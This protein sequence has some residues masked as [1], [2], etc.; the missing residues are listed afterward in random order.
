MS[1]YYR[2]NHNIEPIKDNEDLA[3]SYPK[4]HTQPIVELHRSFA[5]RI[6]KSLSKS[7]LEYLSK[8]LP[9]YIIEP[10]KP[11]NKVKNCRKIFLEIGFGM[12]E[13]LA[14]QATKNTEYYY[15]GCEPYMNGVAN[16]LKLATNNN[17]SNI[18]IWPDTVDDILGSLPEESIDGVYILF[19]DP[20]PKN[21]QQKRRLVNLVR[22]SIIYKAL[23][24]N[25]IV[26]FASDIYHYVDR[27]KEFM[28][29][30]GFMVN[31]LR[32]DEPYAGYVQTKYHLKAEKKATPPKF[33]QFIKI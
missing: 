12:G 20:W 14:Y 28:L 29:Q 27:V 1:F 21:K 25:G 22:M 17:I 8:Q 24:K 15:I 7:Q 10:E 6:G 26:Y 11:L 4:T 31:D 18:A 16:L 5:R 30:I 9:I 23:K 33:L 32:E 2:N 13:H 19:P 3:Q